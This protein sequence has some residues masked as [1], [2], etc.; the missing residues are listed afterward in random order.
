MIAKL[1]DNPLS[2]PILQ[3]LTN[4]QLSIPQI[5]K[6]LQNIDADMPTVIA[7][8][9]ELHNFGFVERVPASVMN[10]PTQ[11]HISSRTEKT[12]S[13][14]DY[15]LIS[16]TPLEIP[17]HN[18]VSLWEDVIQNPDQMNFCEINRWIFSIPDYLRKEIK[19]LTLEEIRQKLSNRGC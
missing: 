8:L 12:K 17:V 18:Y 16:L 2:V 1:L 3:L 7:V 5:T 19:D 11:N 15:K 14:Q 4:K 6:S 13:F 9:S 10:T